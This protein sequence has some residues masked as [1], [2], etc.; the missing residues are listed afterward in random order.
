MRRSELRPRLLD[1]V[2]KR[3]SARRGRSRKRR[4]APAQQAR[5]RGASARRR[6]AQSAPQ[7][8]PRPRS[9][10]RCA[11]ADRRAIE[12]PQ[13][14]WHPLPLSELLILVGAIGTVVGVARSRGGIAA[15]VPTLLARAS[16]RSLIGTVEVTL[17]EHLGGYR[18]HTLILALLPGDR[19]PHGGR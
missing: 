4:P 16:R 10:E 2:A 15:P 18:S 17:R 12:R 6:R 9:R 1:A 13:A 7:A 3:N 5:R 19:V 8:R 11:A 14:P